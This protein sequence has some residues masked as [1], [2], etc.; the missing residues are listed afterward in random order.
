[1]AARATEQLYAPAS[2]PSDLPDPGAWVPPEASGSCF[3][4]DSLASQGL[5]REPPE[6]S[7]SSISSRDSRDALSLSL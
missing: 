2:A 1:M 5:V 4:L 6:A 7:G 3:L